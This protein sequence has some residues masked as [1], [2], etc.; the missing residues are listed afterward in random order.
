MC[1]ISSLPTNESWARVYA[2]IRWTG[3]SVNQF[4]KQIG[5]SRAETLYRIKRGLN[6]VSR[7]MAARIVAHYPAVS[8]GWLLCGEGR[9]FR[10]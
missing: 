9:M 6:G 1:K 2:V 3:L 4:A 7:S 10:Y 8:E 5:L